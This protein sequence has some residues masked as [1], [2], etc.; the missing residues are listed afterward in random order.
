MLE[1]QPDYLILYEI[2][3]RLDYYN[4]DIYILTKYDNSE[5]SYYVKQF[6]VDN[7]ATKVARQ[8]Q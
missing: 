3:Q 6:I 7:S 4:Y 1:D 2:Y 5:L 8:R